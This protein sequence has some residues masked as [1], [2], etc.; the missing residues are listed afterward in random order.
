MKM[1]KIL[2]SVCIPTYNRADVLKKTLTKVIKF[3]DKSIYDLDIIIND[4]A[5]QDDTENYIKG[6]N[7]KYIKY[8]KNSETVSADENFY[9]VLKCA[10]GEYSILLGDKHY[11]IEKNFNEL[12]KILNDFKY[13]AVVTRAKGRNI[14][15]KN[16]VYKNPVL[17]MNDLGWHYTLLSSIVFSKRIIDNFDIATYKWN[18][19]IHHFILT[20]YLF[21]NNS[22]IFWLNKE[23]LE[24]VP[25]VSSGWISSSVEIFGRNWS[26]YILSLPF[27]IPEDTRAKIIKDHSINTNLFTFEY[28]YMLSKKYGLTIKKIDECKEYVKY[29]S[30]IPYEKICDIIDSKFSLTDK[31]RIF[32]YE[33]KFKIKEIIKSSLKFGR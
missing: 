16:N 6:L 33:I 1:N 9:R 20:Q 27:D 14:K 3:I 28:Y 13:S 19:F 29:F 26:K 10:D 31:F 15:I 12:L 7:S 4:N 24:A 11:I 2:L 22:E 21:N 18:N 8:F 17:F 32:V 25:M 5:S 23:I 30:Q